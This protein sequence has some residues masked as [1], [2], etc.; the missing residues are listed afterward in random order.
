MR[1][2][3]CWT[4]FVSCRTSFVR[5]ATTLDRVES[6]AVDA[7]TAFGI[8]LCGVA[9]PPAGSTIEVPSLGDPATSH[10][11][12]PASAAHGLINKI[13]KT[14]RYPLTDRRRLLTAAL[15]ATRQASVLQLLRQA[16]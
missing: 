12:D 5:D 1:L 2:I 8:V 6:K 7:P 3:S 16:A 9:S 11:A 4:S 15:D 13:P 10:G 14:H